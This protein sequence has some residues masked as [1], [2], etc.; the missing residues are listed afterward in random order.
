MN[1]A[2]I[3]Q[4][5]NELELNIHAYEFLLDECMENGKYMILDGEVLD[6]KTFD[7]IRDATEKELTFFYGIRVLGLK[8]KELEKLLPR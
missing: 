2:L 8:V 6:S 7:T 5:I 4:E 3:E 1:K